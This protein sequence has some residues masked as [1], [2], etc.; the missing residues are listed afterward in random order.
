MS[1]KNTIFA[2]ETIV[3]TIL[4]FIPRVFSDDTIPIPADKSQLSSWF[5]ANVKPLD[6]R[7]YTLDPALVAAEANKTIIKV[8]TDGSGDFK[9]LTEAVK[10][11][12][13][14]NKRRVIIWIGGEI[15]LK[16]SKLREINLLLHY[17]E[18]LK[19]SQILYFMELQNNILLLKVPLSLLNLNISVLLISTSWY[20]TAPRPDGKMELAQAAA[21]RIG[22][23]K[24]SLY[25][26]KM[27]G[28]QDTF[29]DDSGKH[30]FKD[31]YIEGTVD[32][33]FGNGK[34]IYLNTEAHVIPGDPMAMVTAHARDAENVDS[35]YSFVHCTITGTGNTAYLGRAWK[36]FG[37]VV[38][39]YSDMTD[40]VHP[41]GWSNNGKPE[42]DK[43]VFYGEYNCKGAGA[44]LEKRVGFTKKLS[45]AEAKPFISLAYIEG[46]KWLLPPVTL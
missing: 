40:V 21:L 28:F 44:A 23:D 12:P 45:D 7:K 43:S 22:G 32:F 39:L 30:F 10:S 42:N 9:T 15:T 33:I 1:G 13:E 37:K 6:A 3:L 5:E 18:T 11:I 27:F 19:M 2:L 4:L 17:M 14:G 16:K 46:S 31:C 8:R 24:A 25:N 35:G 36:P 34:S 38:F 41:E 29:C 26:C 20:N